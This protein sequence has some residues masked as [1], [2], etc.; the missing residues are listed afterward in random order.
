MHRPRDHLRPLH[1]LSLEEVSKAQVK[2]LLVDLLKIRTPKTVE[3]THAVINGIFTE[4]NE[5]GYTKVNPAHGLLNRVLPSKKK[6]VR[7]APDPLPRQDLKALL[8]TAWA[9]LPEPFP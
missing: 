5:L 9:K 2:K 7:S 1:Q 4:A 3:V 6:R 8:D